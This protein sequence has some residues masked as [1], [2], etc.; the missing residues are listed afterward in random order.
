MI[1]WTVAAITPVV[2]GLVIVTTVLIVAGAV[3]IQRARSDVMNPAEDDGPDQLAT[4]R[5]AYEQG[6][7]SFA[8]YRRL[9]DL[10]AE[11]RGREFKLLDKPPA[12]PSN[13]DNAI[14]IETPNAA[15]SPPE[16]SPQAAGDEHG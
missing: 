9:L 10:M 11:R 3:V 1:G 14:A 16:L 4:Y 13:V 7:M 2:I 12:R 5:K 15:T 6:F 8:E